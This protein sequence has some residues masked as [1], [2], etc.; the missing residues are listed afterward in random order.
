MA[1]EDIA[2][3]CSYEVPI[4]GIGTT[5]EVAH[6][7]LVDQHMEPSEGIGNMQHL[8]LLNRMSDSPP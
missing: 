6:T 1:S 8:D 4:P 3:T 5:D 7:A 2:P